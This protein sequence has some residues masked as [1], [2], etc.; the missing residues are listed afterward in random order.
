MEFLF[1][2]VERPCANGLTRCHDEGVFYEQELL[3]DS[4]Q[5]LAPRCCVIDVGANL[6]NHTV[7]WAGVCGV[8]V[9]AVEPDPSLVECLT[10]ALVLNGLQGRVQLIDAVA[11]AGTRVQPVPNPHAPAETAG[12]RCFVTHPDGPIPTLLLDH[13]RVPAPLRVLKVDVDGMERYVLTGATKM[14]DTWHPVIYAECWSHG[15]VDDLAR[16]MRQHRYVRTATFGK[17]HRWQPA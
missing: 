11:G 16:I 6:G 3:M 14:I 15:D 17:T 1:P 5:F 13:L 10:A 9:I 8:Y 4:M 2:V 12:N 7:F